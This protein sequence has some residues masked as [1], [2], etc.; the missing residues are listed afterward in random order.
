MTTRGWT[1]DDDVLARS[2]RRERTKT[3]AHHAVEIGRRIR[4]DA[5]GIRARGDPARE[6]AVVAAQGQHAVARRTR[7]VSFARERTRTQSR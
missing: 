7:R 2:A 3:L 5:P 6:P 1:D 4:G